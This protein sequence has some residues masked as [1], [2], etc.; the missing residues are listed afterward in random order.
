MARATTRRSRPPATRSTCGPGKD[1]IDSVDAP[2]TP[3]R[4]LSNVLHSVSYT[5]LHVPT[6][7]RVAERELVLTRAIAASIA[8]A[9]STTIDGSALVRNRVLA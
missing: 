6:D 2:M 3:G 9:A 5:R 7:P 1:L 4:F 8:I